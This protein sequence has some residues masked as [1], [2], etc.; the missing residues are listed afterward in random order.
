MCF[1]QTD[2]PPCEK[3]GVV[4][5]RQVL[6]DPTSPDELIDVTMLRAATSRRL[7]PTRPSVLREG[8]PFLF[9]GAPPPRAGGSAT[10]FFFP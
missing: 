4:S 6:A 10:L 2:P 9:L 5:T 3:W 1:L 8:P 7:Q